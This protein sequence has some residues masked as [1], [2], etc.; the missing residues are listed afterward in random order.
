MGNF[1]HL[2]GTDACVVPVLDKEE[3][4]SH[5]QN[6]ARNSFLPSGEPHI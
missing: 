1:L 6:K 3:A 5:Q 2:D 4:G